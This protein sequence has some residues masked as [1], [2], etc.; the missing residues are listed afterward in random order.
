MTAREQV[1]SHLDNLNLAC[2][3][4]PDVDDNAWEVWLDSFAPA[5]LCREC[6]AV[7]QLKKGQHGE[8]YGCSRYPKCKYTEDA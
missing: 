6:G 1:Q 4:A 5:R 2:H 7:L 3:P 8:F